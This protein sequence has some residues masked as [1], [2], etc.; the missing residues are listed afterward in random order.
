MTRMV[1]FWFSPPSSSPGPSLARGS[2][3]GRG[4]LAAAAPTSATEDEEDLKVIHAEKAPFIQM[5]PGSRWHFK[6]R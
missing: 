4:A 6:P 2:P 5:S 1:P 3:A